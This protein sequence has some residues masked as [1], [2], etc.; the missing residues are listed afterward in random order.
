[1]KFC[2]C[3]SQIFILS[4]P[5]PVIPLNLPFA[6]HTL[7]SISF[8][9][10]NPSPFGVICKV[11][12]LSKQHSFDKSKQ[13]KT[14]SMT[15]KNDFSDFSS[16]SST[17]FAFCFD[18]SFRIKFPNLPYLKHH[19]LRLRAFGLSSFSFSHYVQIFSVNDIPLWSCIQYVWLPRSALALHDWS[20]SEYI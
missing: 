8:I 4:S 1:M 6:R 19:R 20:S 7:W 17:W 2:C 10:S 14:A 9:F 5:I 12:P 15:L 11:Q 13:L 3:P 18:L 16:S